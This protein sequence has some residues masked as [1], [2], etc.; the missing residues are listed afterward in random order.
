[1]TAKIQIFE[2]GT[3]PDLP[4]WSRIGGYDP[5]DGQIYLPVELCTHDAA[6]AVARFHAEA[7]PNEYLSY[8]DNAEGSRVV[9]ASATFLRRCYPVAADDIAYIEHAAKR[10]VGDLIAA[11]LGPPK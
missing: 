8:F 7:L 10:C 1:M 5:Q 2:L 9:L 4:P 6:E 3:T 11:G